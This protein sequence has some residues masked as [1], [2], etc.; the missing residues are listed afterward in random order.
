MHEKKCNN[1]PLRSC[2]FTLKEMCCSVMQTKFYTPVRR[3]SVPGPSVFRYTLEFLRSAITV[4]AECTLTF[5]VLIPATSL[6]GSNVMDRY[7]DRVPVRTI[8]SGT[9]YDGK[10]WYELLSSIRCINGIPTSCNVEKEMLN[11]GDQVTLM[12]KNRTYSGVVDPTGCPG[13]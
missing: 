3:I 9:R 6:A 11:D 1:F 7:K 4:T 12:Y 8:D 10:V 5:R 13:S 2:P